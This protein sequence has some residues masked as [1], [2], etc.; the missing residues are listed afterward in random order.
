MK[1][2]ARNPLFY[3]SVILTGIIVFQFA[4]LVRGQT[5]AWQPPTAPPPGGQPAPPLDTKTN[6]TKEGLLTLKDG[7]KLEKDLVLKNGDQTIS[8]DWATKQIW[9]DKDID[10]KAGIRFWPESDGVWRLQASNDRL[11]PNGWFPLG[12]GTGGGGGVWQT[13][14]APGSRT[15]IYYIGGNVGVGTNNPQQAL[16]VRGTVAATSF[17]KLVSG[18][19]CTPLTG[20]DS[21]TGVTES[22]WQE[23]ESGKIR[24]DG[25]V[26]IGTGT[27][28]PASTLHVKASIT[29]PL[30][31][32]QGLTIEGAENNFTAARS[33]RLF[34]RGTDFHIL[35]T[36]NSVDD[37]LTIRSNGDV[38]IGRGLEGKGTAY[39]NDATYFSS[40]TAL[41]HSTNI[42]L[43]L[44]DNGRVRLARIASGGGR[45][46]N[47]AGETIGECELG[48]VKII[49]Q[50][51]RYCN[52]SFSCS[53]MSVWQS[54]NVV[55]DV[56]LVGAGQGDFN[57]CVGT[58][59]DGD[60][61]VDNTGADNHE[62]Q[63]I[64]DILGP[65]GGL[66]AEPSQG[67]LQLQSP[68][69]ISENIRGERGIFF[70]SPFA[71]E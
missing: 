15:S 44:D 58:Q 59:G 23:T 30:T 34:M 64:R 35:R 52:S 45:V 62:Q 70:R 1:A 37:G 49:K 2:L 46:I 12:S 68:F 22:F 51:I 63:T 53:S 24:Y 16:E 19:G 57:V 10:L 4:Q 60:T 8:L 65:S 69:Y 67:G 56:T 6:Q 50:S 13:A 61:G 11:N 7:L 47:E 27:Q 18:G 14:P 71:G 26:G 25:R 5:S 48:G 20:I 55:T 36:T 38:V 42:A 39:L 9:F 43:T 21:V 54:I 32:T 3:L 29:S 41:N 40:I 31:S 17:C 33:A 28:P 66:V